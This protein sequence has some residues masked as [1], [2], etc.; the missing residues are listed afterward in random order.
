MENEICTTDD[1]VEAVVVEEVCFIQFQSSWKGR[2]KT[3]QMGDFLLIAYRSDCSSD[4]VSLPQLAFHEKS[5]TH[6]PADLPHR[7]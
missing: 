4:V 6:V 5:S 1:L 3:L 2:C 7:D